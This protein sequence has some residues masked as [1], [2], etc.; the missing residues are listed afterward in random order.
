[1]RTGVGEQGDPLTLDRVLCEGAI[2]IT[3]VERY[4]SYLTKLQMEKSS[5]LFNHYDQANT[6][7]AKRF[8]ANETHRARVF[9]VVRDLGRTDG[10]RPKDLKAARSLKAKAREVLVKGGFTE[11]NFEAGWKQLTKADEST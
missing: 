10:T 5:P 9:K 6:V 2:M 8:K 1:M 11:N 7:A 3:E 4:E